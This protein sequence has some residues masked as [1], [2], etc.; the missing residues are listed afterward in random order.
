M[1]VYRLS[2]PPALV[3]MDEYMEHQLQDASPDRADLDVEAFSNRGV[4]VTILGIEVSPSEERE[5]TG[6]LLEKAYLSIS[7]FGAQLLTYWEAGSPLCGQRANALLF[8][9]SQTL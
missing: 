7:D 3:M 4:H 2:Q 1:P 9:S 5:M 6:R 8:V